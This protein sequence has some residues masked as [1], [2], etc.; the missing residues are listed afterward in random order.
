M[1]TLNVEILILQ[2]QVWIIWLK[3]LLRLINSVSQSQSQDLRAK[4]I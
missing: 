2:Y 4:H 3:S 1:F